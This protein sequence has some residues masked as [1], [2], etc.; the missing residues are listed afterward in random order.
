MTTHVTEDAPKTEIVCRVN[1]S[2]EAVAALQAMHGVD[3]RGTLACTVFEELLQQAA[4]QVQKQ[5]DM[6]IGAVQNALRDVKLDSVAKQ[7]GKIAV[8]LSE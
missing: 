8:K 5:T 3:V 6:D 2:P 4:L 1:I 7:F